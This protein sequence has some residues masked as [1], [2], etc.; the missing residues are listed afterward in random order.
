MG[1]E[2]AAVRKLLL[3]AACGW[4]VLGAGCN[5]GP[6]HKAP[7][8]TAPDAQWPEAMEAGLSTEVADVREWWRG[9]GDEGLNS[10]VERSLEGSLDLREAVARVR[11]ARA[12]RGV[13]AADQWPTVDVGGSGT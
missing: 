11:E 7:Q 1:Y 9:F 6:D 2:I 3:A 13:V 4:G 8:D 5:V 10:L 12:L